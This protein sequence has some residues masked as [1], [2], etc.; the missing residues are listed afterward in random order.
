MAHSDT[1]AITDAKYKDHDSLYNSEVI[2][3]NT[4]GFIKIFNTAVKPKKLKTIQIKIG[5]NILS[6]INRVVDLLV[7]KLPTTRLI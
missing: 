6:R 3:K 7:T 1:L 4:I 5:K 2:L